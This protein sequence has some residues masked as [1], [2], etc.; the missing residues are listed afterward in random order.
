MLARLQLPSITDLDLEWD[1]YTGVVEAARSTCTLPVLAAAPWFARLR[2]LKLSEWR[3]AFGDLAGRAAPA[4]E[5][6]HVIL[7]H[8]SSA[9]TADRLA[10]LERL[11]MP[12]LRLLELDFGSAR[13]APIPRAGLAALL[14]APGLGTSLQELYLQFAGAG[15]DDASQ[16]AAAA[17][18]AVDLPALRRLAF[19]DTSAGTAAMAKATAA[20]RWAPQLEELLFGTPLPLG[21]GA[22]AHIAAALAA[23]AA[24]PLARLQR[25]TL[26]DWMP[27]PP[28]GALQ[29][30]LC[31]PWARGLSVIELP[32]LTEAEV[33]HLVLTCPGLLE[34]CASGA[35]EVRVRK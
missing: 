32:E 21:A 4:L 24:A 11:A 35:L 5:T 23:L 22:Q 3:W 7:T 1:I 33:E 31:A 28:V 16:H 8:N 20:A 14:A 10:E 12:R 25:L 9:P 27:A 29:N 2:E 18:A 19:T 13:S 17:L 6:L 26:P 34:R 30:L 15:S